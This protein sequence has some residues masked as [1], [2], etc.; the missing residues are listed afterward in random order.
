MVEDLLRG[1][2]SFVNH[3]KGY[4]TIDYD[5]KGKRKSVTGRTGQTE[6]KQLGKK[7]HQFRIGDEVSFRVTRSERGDKMVAVDV[8]FLYNQEVEKLV[9]RATVEN[10]FSGYLKVVDDEL[11]VKEWDSYI[12]FRLRLSNWENAPAP[13]AFNVPISFR[14]VNMD[15]PH[16]M[17]AELFS[18]DYI[19]EFRQAQEMFHKRQAVQA[20][21]LKISPFAVYVSLLG[22]DRLQAKIP[23]PA[24]GWEGKVVGDE[25]SL[26]ITYI[27]DSKLTVELVER[28]K[29]TP[30][31][32][33]T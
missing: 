15:K 26:F 8:K 5:D 21:I 13:A 24:E 27:S 30:E 10:R 28:G 2:V 4:M 17:S 16:A 23:L 29:G 3:A 22:S 11:Y 32:P 9:N 18:H 31:T 14:L 20:R 7:E 25:I 6:K 19:P 33:L 12:F 1:I